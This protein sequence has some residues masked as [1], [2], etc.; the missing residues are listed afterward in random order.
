MFLRLRSAAGG[1]RPLK[2]PLAGQTL[3]PTTTPP[4]VKANI[5]WSSLSLLKKEPRSLI[6]DYSL[7]DLKRKRKKKK[8]MDR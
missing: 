7:D 1:I 3:E 8:K 4:P 5:D 2:L 6:N